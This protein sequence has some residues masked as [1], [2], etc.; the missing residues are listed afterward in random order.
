MSPQRIRLH[1]T[2]RSRKP[3]GVVVV[4]WP[5]R[6]RNPYT[7]KMMQKRI[8]ELAEEFPAEE[9]ADLDPRAMAVEAFESD[10][11]Y[12]PDSRWW[13]FGPHMSMIAICGDI[14]LLRGKDLG[15]WCP[16]P[17]PGEPDICHAAVL[18]DIANSGAAQGGKPA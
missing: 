6:W 1:R 5:S 3:D 15:C 9:L 4:G 11:R 13:W 8:D 14:G 7:L 18:I 17:A 16:L 2:K 10:L 12:G